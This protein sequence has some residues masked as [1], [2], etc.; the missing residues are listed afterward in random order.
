[1]GVVWGGG[2]EVEPVVAHP[3]CAKRRVPKPI[4]DIAEVVGPLS[5][6]P[7]LG[8]GGVAEYGITVRWDKNF[9]DLNYILLMRRKKFRLL[10]GV[11]FGG[12]LTLDDAWDLGFHHVAIAAGA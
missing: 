12:T 8:F 1:G 4:R 3:R 9:L 5:E 11:R 10:D 7:T 2:G 6:R